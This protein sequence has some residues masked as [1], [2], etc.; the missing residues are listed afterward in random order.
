MVEH[1]KIEVS[2]RTI[3]FSVV[4]TALFL[5]STQLVWRFRNILYALFLAYILTCALRPW[6]AYL[7]KKRLKRLPATILVFFPT[8][9]LV[10]F[11]V[12]VI[13]PP[14]LVE[15]IRFFT[16]L[17]NLILDVF[18]IM[19]SWVQPELLEKT[20]TSMTGSIPEITSNFVKIA[21]GV[22]TNIAFIASILFFTF[23]FLLEERLGEFYIPKFLGKRHAQ[24][25]F[26][27]LGKIEKRM[28][29]WVGGQLLLMCVIGLATYAGLTLLKIPYALPLA[30]IAGILEIVPILGPLF[31]VVPAFFVTASVSLPLGVLVLGLYFFIQQ[32]ENTV[33]VP[34]VMRRA[35]GLHP[36]L[37][38]I[39]LSIGGE[40]GGHVGVHSD[41]AHSGRIAISTQ[42][43]VEGDAF[44]LNVALGL[45]QSGFV[46]LHHM[47]QGCFVFGLQVGF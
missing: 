47:A 7:Q 26:N 14:V 40:L 39:A 3:V 29:S 32:L 31:S 36:I 13:I 34:Y 44:F 42:A 24:M 41:H 9:F 30:F 15:S 8:L 6:V 33:V 17:P 16:S 19:Q 2:K 22:F 10:F 4:F 11:L 45:A 38:L 35:V 21:G 27:V 25:V 28:S 37:T 20:I 46:H 43:L 23:Y 1:M 18:P 5:L 12:S